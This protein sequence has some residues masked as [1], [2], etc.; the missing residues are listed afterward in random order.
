MTGNVVVTDVGAL[1]HVVLSEVDKHL[2]YWELVGT[3]ESSLVLYKYN[4]K[5]IFHGFYLTI[6]RK[7]LLIFA[8]AET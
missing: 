3:T 1:M 6:F 7:I 8:N 5:S 2:P 4:L